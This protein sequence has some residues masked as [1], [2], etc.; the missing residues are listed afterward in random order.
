MRRIHSATIELF[1]CVA[2]SAKVVAYPE[3]EPGAPG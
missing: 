3:K 2:I 1:H